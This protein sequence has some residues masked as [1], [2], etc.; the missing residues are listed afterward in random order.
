MIF[1]N[2]SNEL[3][4]KIQKQCKEKNDY[5]YTELIYNN[6]KLPT[7]QIIIKSEKL[8]KFHNSI[9]KEIIKRS[10]LEYNFKNYF[11]TYIIKDIIDICHEKNLCTISQIG[12]LIIKKEIVKID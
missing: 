2:Y 8:D 10:D 4:L 12:N 11:R 7:D 3:L 1:E 6:K 5:F 9:N